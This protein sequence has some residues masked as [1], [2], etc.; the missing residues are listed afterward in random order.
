MELDYFMF[1]K[2]F[3]VPVIV[4]A[5]I[6]QYLIQTIGGWVDEHIR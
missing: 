5:I 1:A 3:V 2:L 4:S 6:S